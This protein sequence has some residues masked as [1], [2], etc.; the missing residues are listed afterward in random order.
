[1][2]ISKDVLFLETKFPF[3]SE[4]PPALVATF[5]VLPLG[6]IQ[7]IRSVLGYVW[8]FGWKGRR[9]F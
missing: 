5:R 8:E 7:T 3:S 1:M 6:V 9:E 4:S 2:F